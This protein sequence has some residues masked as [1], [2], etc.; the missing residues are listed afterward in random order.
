MNKLGVDC[1]NCR[2]PWVEIPLEQLEGLHCGVTALC[3][4]CGKPIVFGVF[5]R[6]EY[7]KFIM[8]PV[9]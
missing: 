5:S 8:R 9:E 7:A 2:D 6:D 3:P 4:K 1:P